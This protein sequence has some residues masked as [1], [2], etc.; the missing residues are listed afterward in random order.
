M[1]ATP[2]SRTTSLRALLPG[3]QETD[4]APR[5]AL[6]REIGRRPGLAEARALPWAI[7]KVCPGGRATTSAWETLIV[8]A[9]AASGTSRSL[10]QLGRSS[11]MH[12]ACT[13][14]RATFGNGCRIATWTPMP[15][16]PPMARYGPTEIAV[17]ESFAERQLS[18]AADKPSYML[19]PA[20]CQQEIPWVSRCTTK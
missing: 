13:I 7:H 11:P 1:S 6:W 10:L 17:A 15:V 9:A 8:G 14:W 18:P 4:E 2:F 12:S 19:W 20:S 5:A 3:E 16:H